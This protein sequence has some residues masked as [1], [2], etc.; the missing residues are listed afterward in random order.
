MAT[1]F[2]SFDSSTGG[3][4]PRKTYL[5]SGDKESGKEEFAYKFTASSLSNKAGAVYITTNKASGDLISEF[6]ARSLN[7][8]QYLG[9]TLKI[10]DNFTRSISPTATDNP[11]T[12]IL[13][14]P[15]DLTGLS[16]ALSN[17]N[18]DFLKDG[19]PVINVFDSISS[20]LLY[21][22]LVTVFRFMQFICG[23]SKMSGVTTVFLIDNQ[24][25][26]PDV[27]ETVKSLIDGVIS[28]KLENGKRY[29]RIAGVS[30]EVLNWTELA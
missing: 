5:L 22:N 24:M 20:L 1:G 14:G 15:L 26:M 6:G 10:L 19:R 9:S 4:E 8:S 18:S 28:L 29:F 7:I 21:N 16:V 12:K 30:K 23:R 25:H 11:Y 17:V 2:P 13:N 27:N 3:L